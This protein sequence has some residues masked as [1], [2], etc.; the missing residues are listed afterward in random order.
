MSAEFLCTRWTLLILRELLFGSTSFNDIS[1]GVPRMSRSLLSSRLKELIEVGVLEK[2]EGGSGQSCY[3]L[4]PAGM[5]L[6][7]VVLSMAGWGQKWL[8]VGPSL[9]A[10]DVGLLMWDIRRNV[11]PMAA[12]PNPFIVEFCLSGVPENQS[13]HWLV[14]K[15]DVVDL[16][17]IDHGFDVDVVIEVEARKL[18]RVWMGWENMQAAIDRGEMQLKGRREYT[19]IACQWLGCSR[20]AK[21]SKVPEAMRI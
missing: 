15:D 17:H 1:R 6:E 7:S 14:F 19:Q 18:T 5:A 10:L 11:K 4:T 12:L 9:E 16:C 8:K 2:R 21:I 20:V 13:R 3:Q